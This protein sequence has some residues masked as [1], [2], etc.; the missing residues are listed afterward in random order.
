MKGTM[1]MQEK[2]FKEQGR[3]FHAH[4]QFHR[5]YFK[6]NDMDFAFQWLM[7]SAV[8][9]GAAIGE[10]FYAASRIKDG[11]PASWER[12]W[13]SF[14]DRVRQRA[15]AALAGGHIVSGREAYLRAAAYY[16]AVLGSMR[17]AHPG[18]RTT[19]ARVRECFQR[20]AGLFEPPVERVEIP[21]DGATLPGYFQAAGVGDR[22]S[23]TLLMIGGGETFTEDLYYF[24]APAAHK[25]GYNFMTVDL[26]GQGDL[27][28]HG[29]YFRADVETP[30]RSV[31]DY[32]L[33]RRDVDPDRFAA[34]G[35]SAGGYMVPRAAAHDT[36]IKACVANS[37]ICNMYNIFRDSPISKVRGLV[38]RVA[39]WKR[40][41]QMRMI[42]L[43]AWRW[44]IEG[45]DFAAL[46]EKNRHV[47]FDPAQICCPTLILIGEGEYQN[48]EIRRQQ[49]SAMDAMTDPRNRLIIGPLDEGA[50]HHC[51]GENLGLMS[52]LVF[53]WLDEV[54][55]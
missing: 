35:I 2:T 52:A 36:R 44:G 14:G 26:P 30:M 3:Q 38:R 55:A 29:Q 24:I 21:F 22:P 31:I 50:A 16:R 10:G 20:G 54:L 12:E 27:P 4:R 41:F 15:E 8:H 6:A 40:P 17:P 43:I 28:F 9:G 46:V 1:A 33:S 13:T 51:L 25:R 53:D 19:V 47:V 42:E 39:A 49:H 18:F 11:D 48:P 37:M 23:R 45:S 7:G 34:Y 32:A 5:M